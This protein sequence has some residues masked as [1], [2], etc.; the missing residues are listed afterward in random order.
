[1]CGLLALPKRVELTQHAHLALH[2]RL[3]ELHMAR[4]DL[5]ENLLRV[6]V[7]RAEPP[8]LPVDQLVDLL[9]RPPQARHQGSQVLQRRHAP[10]IVGKP[11]EILILLIEFLDLLAIRPVVTQRRPLEGRR[12]LDG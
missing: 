2:R 4:P 9:L 10:A 6:L 8:V 11:A 5:L 12:H 7:D 3:G 1:M